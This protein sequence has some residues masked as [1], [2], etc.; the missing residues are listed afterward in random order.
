MVVVA[1]VAWMNFWSSQYNYFAA[2]VVTVIVLAVV[3]FWFNS[4][5]RKWMSFLLMSKSRILSRAMSRGMSLK[6]AKR[7]ERSKERN[8]CG[9]DVGGSVLEQSAK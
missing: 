4:I 3:V 7:G 1:L 5:S 9:N 6:G 2:S 8:Q